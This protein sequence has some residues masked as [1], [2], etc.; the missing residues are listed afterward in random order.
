MRILGADEV[1][2][3]VAGISGEDDAFVLGELRTHARENGL[4]AICAAR[5]GADRRSVRAASGRELRDRR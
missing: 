1:V 5:T 2:V 4:A 3:P